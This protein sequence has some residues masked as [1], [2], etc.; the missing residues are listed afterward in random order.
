MMI[1]L[2]ASGVPPDS[3]SNG[4]LI[5]DSSNR[6]T[7][8]DGPY[9]VPIRV[10]ATA[11]TTSDNDTPLSFRWKPE[12]K[13]CYAYLHFAE[14]ENLQS[15]EFREFDISVNGEQPI[16]KGIRVLSSPS[17]ITNLGESL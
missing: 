2:I 5:N 6:G 11:I 8:D 4:K 15:N 1:L 12:T 9:K 10:M 14:V 16:A 7:L 17:E 3:P 13:N